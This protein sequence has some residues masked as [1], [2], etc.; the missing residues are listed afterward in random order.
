M[1]AIQSDV[2]FY[3]PELRAATMEMEYDVTDYSDPNFSILMA[4]LQP[5]SDSIVIPINIAGHELLALVDTGAT[6]N[7]ITP[8]TVTQLGLL[9]TSPESNSSAIQVASLQSVPRIGSCH[10]ALAP[11]SS[12]TNRRSIVTSFELMVLSA[13]SQSII[14]G[15]P[16]LSLL[17]IGF[18][19]LPVTHPTDSKSHSQDEVTPGY[20]SSSN[21][22]DV[23]P[24][25]VGFEDCLKFLSNNK[26]NADLYYNYLGLGL[27]LLLFGRNS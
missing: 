6:H 17:G 11:I 2:P 25:D 4:I 13:D 9:V 7:F 12:D 14:L 5:Y 1:A 16:T 24:A 22:Q 21:E 8:A 26:V 10:Q 15:L 27:G 3:D 23:T 19:G 18:F 20:H